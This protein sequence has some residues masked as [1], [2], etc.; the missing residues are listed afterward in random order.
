MTARERL[1]RTQRLL[2]AGVI[3]S[4]LGW[5]AAVFLLVLAVIA[6]ATFLIRSAGSL[7]DIAAPLAGALGVATA[8]ALLWRGRHVASTSRV[9]LWIE[10]RLPRLQYALVTATE[11]DIASDHVSLESAVARE[12]IPGVA[13]TALRRSVLPAAVAL[14]AAGALLYVSPPSAF[15]RSAILGRLGE[16]RGAGTRLAGSRLTGLRVEVTPPAYAR[17]S[18]LTLDDPASVKALVGSA[19]I[20]TGSGSANGVTVRA[21]DAHPPVNGSSSGWRAQ[22][23]MPAKPAALTLTDRSYE[24]IIVLEPQ[25]DESPMVTLVSSVRDTIVRTPQLTVRLHAETTDDVGLTSGYF[26]YLITSGSGEIFTGRTINTPPVEF[27]RARSGSLDATLD[28][29]TLKLQQ[30]DVVSVRAIV[31]D[32]N[33]LSGPSIGA[34]ETRT[35]RVARSDEYDSVSVEAAAPPAV[36]S[37]AMSQRML[38]MMTE[39]LV[40]KQRT[41]SRSQ[42]VKQSTDIGASED[43]IRKRVYDI[44]YQTESQAAPADTEEAESEVHAI[45]NK[46]LKQAYDALW[47]AVRSLQIAEPTAALPPMRVALQALDRARVAQRLYLRGAPPKIIVD[48]QRVRLTG[49]EKGSGNVRTPRP[50]AD[51]VHVSLSA[52]FNA[53]IDLIATQPARARRD[54]ALMR[55][56]ALSSLPDFAAALAEAMDAMRSGREATLPL[57]RARR[58]LN[59]APR[60]TPGLSEWSG[61]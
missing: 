57:L 11:S 61:G 38:V 46:D 31:R 27:N 34:S 16:S 37:S 56:D 53:A 59:G 44:L 4:S 33:A 12:D 19:I 48:L 3:L 43:R 5:G 40:R 50:F 29:G 25:I 20:V 51:S 7:G 2:G 23:L 1:S 15:G 22:L 26:E 36:D 10:E 35:F 21:V 32:D 54:F 9:A 39:A 18:R 24:R 28:L 30:G 17:Q 13:T 49:K 52:R 58:V 6:F 41:I 47:D 42:W 14:L 8:V 60:V 45:A 55:V